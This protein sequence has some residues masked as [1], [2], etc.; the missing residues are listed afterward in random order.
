[1]G[2][3]AFAFPE[4]RVLAVTTG[5]AFSYDAYTEI[6]SSRAAL[7]FAAFG[8]ALAMNGFFTNW[9][10]ASEGDDVIAASDT[11]IGGNAS[12]SYIF[13]LVK[14]ALTASYKWYPGKLW[15]GTKEEY[16]AGISITPRSQKTAQALQAIPT[17][18]CR[19]D[20]TLY[21]DSRFTGNITASSSWRVKRKGVSVSAKIEA[22]FPI[23]KP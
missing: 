13:P 12:L 20:A 7:S 1:M 21:A 4:A 6:C 14:P 8:A 11:T 5:N 17:A 2:G 9:K 15:Q 22:A 16:S 23:T 19:F 10:I 3:L 18:S